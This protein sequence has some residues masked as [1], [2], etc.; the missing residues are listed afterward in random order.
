MKERLGS[1]DALRGAV[2]II[3]ALDHVRDFV[4]RGAMSG[5]SPTALASTTPVL[6]LTRWVT[7]FCAP[8]FMLAAGL[9]AYFYLSN[10]R[11]KGQLA[12]FLV[13]RGLWLIVLEVTLMQLAYNFD[14]ASTYP[15]FLLVLWAL[16]ACMI[17]LAG[18]IWLPI[19]LLAALSIAVI[20]LHHLADGVRLQGALILLHQVGAFPFAGR[21]FIAPYTLVPWF[22]VMA[23]GFCL[24]PVFS[25]DADRRRRFLLRAGIAATIAFLVVRVINAYGDPSRWAWESSATLTVLSFLNTSKYPPSLLFLLMTLGPA[26]ILLS[27]LGDRR[28][29]RSN[30]LIVFGRVP[31]FYFVLHFFAA[32]AAIVALSLARY[33]PAALDFM[34]QPV[35]SMG[36]PAKSFPPDFGY[37]LWVAYAVWIALVV[38]LYP[39][40]R[41]FAA[42][43]ERNRSWWLSYL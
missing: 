9:G 16:G 29:S 14:V 8:V 4:H 7:H 10:G 43:K 39:L 22:A 19:P 23:L 36:G 27:W 30:P 18:L 13:T 28:L 15:I 32:H 11:T 20:V 3:M 37:D 35:P 1:V 33:G 25:W 31:L 21:M 40:C 38:A 2:M 34:F 24:G 26:L 12:R 5:A 6:F 42:L 17:I 41:W